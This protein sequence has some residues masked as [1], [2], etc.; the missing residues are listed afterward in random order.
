MSFLT[1]N[2]SSILSHRTNMFTCHHI[3]CLFYRY[4]WFL[5][6]TFTFVVFI[7]LVWVCMCAYAC[8]AMHASAGVHADICVCQDW[9]RLSDALV[10]QSSPHSFE[11]GSINEG[12]GRQ[13]TRK[14]YCLHH[15]RAGNRLQTNM[16]PQH[17]LNFLYGC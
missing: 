2:W 15:H 17:F 3:S 5:F 1:E 8:A 12:G 11:R 7:V 6:I 16:H 10:Y 9:R 4:L 14:P 13:T